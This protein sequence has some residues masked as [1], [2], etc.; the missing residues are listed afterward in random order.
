[1]LSVWPY[2]P[3]LTF[4]CIEWSR[5]SILQKFRFENK[6]GLKKKSYERCIYESVDE[7]RLYWDISQKSMKNRIH[8]AKGYRDYRK[9]SY[10][11]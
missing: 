3:I 7:K 2:F 9:K 11:Q 4:S 1:M 6:K 8:A 10:F 5:S